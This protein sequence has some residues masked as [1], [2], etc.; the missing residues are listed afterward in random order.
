MRGIKSLVTAVPVLRY[1]DINKLVTIQ[2]DSSQTGLGCCFLQEGQ[3]V[4]FA[5]RALS[6]TEQNYVQIEK[7]CLSIAFA[8]QHF[9][10]TSLGGVMLLQRLTTARP[11]A[12][13][14]GHHRVPDKLRVKH[15][16]AK[17]TYDRSV[18]DLPEL[19][20]GQP[21][22]MMPLSGEMTTNGG[23]VYACNRW[24]PGPTLSA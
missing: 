11:A 8:C 24:D 19:N 16:A 18:K 7:E 4:V 15:Q 17:Q 1:Y 21:V 13:T 3:A 2:N 6:Q 12:G 20:A 10:T 23:E 9:I 5:S 14:S 22:R